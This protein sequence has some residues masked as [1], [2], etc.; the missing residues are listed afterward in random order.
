VRLI[1]VALSSRMRRDRGPLPFRFRGGRLVASLHK[2]QGR[3]AMGCGLRRM[4]S[5][6]RSD[7]P[8]G[9]L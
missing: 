7:H 9:R 4:P 2:W 6:A 5:S 8:P 1:V 3:G